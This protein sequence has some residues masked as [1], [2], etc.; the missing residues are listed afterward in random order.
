MCAI[1]R[2]VPRS[3]TELFSYFSGTGEVDRPPTETTPGEKNPAPVM[4]G[5]REPTRTVRESNLPGDL[6]ATFRRQKSLQ[7][8]DRQNTTRKYDR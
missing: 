8:R 7:P 5:S 3:P 2:N 4:D 1:R 6:W